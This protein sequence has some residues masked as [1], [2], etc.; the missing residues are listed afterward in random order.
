MN[1]LRLRLTGLSPLSAAHFG[2]G[3]KATHLTCRQGAWSI[4]ASSPRVLSLIRQ[5]APDTLS[6]RNIWASS[7]KLK[8]GRISPAPPVV[9]TSSLL[10]DRP[11]IN[12]D[13]RRVRLQ[14]WSFRVE[15]AFWRDVPRTLKA[16]RWAHRVPV[17][18]DDISGHVSGPAGGEVGGR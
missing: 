6:R 7:S 12:Q 1:A 8:T 9:S 10:L 2:G 17:Y 15:R 18:D 3:F 14:T 11:R 13:G 16:F 4:E 5:P